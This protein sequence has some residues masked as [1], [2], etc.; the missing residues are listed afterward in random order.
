MRA[1]SALCIHDVLISLVM[2]CSFSMVFSLLLMIT[3]LLIYAYLIFILAQ[4]LNISSCSVYMQHCIFASL[5][6]QFLCDCPWSFLVPKHI[7]II[8]WFRVFWV[9]RSKYIL[10]ISVF[11]WFTFLTLNR[12]ILAR[13]YFL[14]LSDIC[15]QKSYNSNMCQFICA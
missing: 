15:F 11:W 7:L 3:L 5:K 10:Y 9:L 4:D 8:Q 12:I 2:C 13:R 14:F 1:L 6:R